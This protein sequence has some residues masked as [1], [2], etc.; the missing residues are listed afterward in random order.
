MDI[1]W[2]LPAEEKFIVNITNLLPVYELI[3][4]GQTYL[5]PID[6]MFIV[7][8]TNLLPVKFLLSAITQSS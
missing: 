6:E 5:L 4:S 3:I 2:L 8:V 7:N 1:T